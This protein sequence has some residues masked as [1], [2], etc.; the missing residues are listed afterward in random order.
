MG[1]D[2]VVY[3]ESDTPLQPLFPLGICID[4]CGL[5]L[6]WTPE[7]CTLRLPDHRSLE[8]QREEGSIYLAEDD[9]EVLRQLRAA[10]RLARGRAMVAQAIRAAVSLVEL[11]R[12]RAEGHP[13]FMAE[14]RECRLAAGRMRSH[15]RLDPA[16]RPG[17]QLSA[18]L[19]GPHPPGRWPS[20]LQEDAPKRA[21]YFL[22]CAYQVLTQAEV[23]QQ[24]RNIADAR[25]A[26][27][28]GDTGPLVEVGAD[29]AGASGS[30]AD[31]DAREE[32]DDSGVKVWYFTVPLER[33]TAEEC[34]RGL[35]AVVGAIG[36]EFQGQA[37]FRIHAVRAS[38]LS[39]PRVRDHFAKK[40]IVVT[41]APGY[42]SN[43]NGCAER[44]IGIIKGRAR[45]MLMS[46]PIADQQW[47]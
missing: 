30:D 47:L 39:G 43:N 12:H 35:D 37:V 22:L 41:R 36:L 29:V 5:G 42:E 27:A 25:A 14:C 1:E 15:F 45:A 34:I 6:E 2:D 17:G 8:L 32:T 24:G 23:K 46:L 31:G 7:E 20:S 3:V 10:M 11:G 26:A 40:Q 4:E 28:A 19:S 44:G 33:K 21:Q 13:T 9:A 16:T 38:E 18:D